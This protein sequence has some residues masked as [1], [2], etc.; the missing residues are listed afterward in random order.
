MRN[1]AISFTLCLYSASQLR[2]DKFIDEIGAKF[3]VETYRDLQLYTIRHYNQ[4]II[5]NLTKEKQVMFTEKNE[6][7]IQMVIKNRPAI[8]E[9]EMVK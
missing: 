6:K 8:Q 5:E 2:L 1:S 4:Y 9:K 3:R 7:T